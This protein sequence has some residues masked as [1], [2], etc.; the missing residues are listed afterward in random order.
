MRYVLV[1]LAILVCGVAHAQEDLVQPSVDFT[2]TAVH[3]IGWLRQTET[4][5][6]TAGRL[7]ID[8]G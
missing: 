2:A 7:R 3:E 8:S 6:Y 1:F 5:H 4:I